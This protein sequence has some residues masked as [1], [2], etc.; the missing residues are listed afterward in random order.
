MCKLL[1]VLKKV[2]NLSE[3]VGIKTMNEPKTK[4]PNDKEYWHLLLHNLLLGQN[5][6]SVDELIRKIS[7]H[8]KDKATIGYCVY[9]ITELSDIANQAIE[10]SKILGWDKES[11]LSLGEKRYQEKKSEFLKRHPEGVWV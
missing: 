11:L 4:I 2:K 8:D 5:K 1:N 6:G 3:D 7:R 10:M 9:L